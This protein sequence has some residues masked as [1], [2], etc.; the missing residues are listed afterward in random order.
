MREAGLTGM[1][2]Q[3]LSIKLEID[4]KPPAG[5]TTEN[6]IIDRHMIVAV[7]HH[8]LPSLLAGKIH[9]LCT[10]KF[11]KARDWYDIIWYAARRQVLTPNTKLLDSALKQTGHDTLR[12]PSKWQAHLIN[13]I[14]RIDQSKLRKDIKPFLEEPKEADLLTVDNLKKAIMQLH[15]KRFH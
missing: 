5:A 15:T 13:R 14:E 1:A 6:N 11:L 3:K 12:E 2:E 9:A 7:R 10:R 8:D 4:S